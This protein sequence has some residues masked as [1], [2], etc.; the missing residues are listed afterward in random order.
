MRLLRDQRG[1]T[2]PELLVSSIAFIVVLSSILMITTVATHN[3]DRI[4][5]RVNANQRIRPVMTRVMDGLHSA[6]VT[7]G[8]VPIATSSAAGSTTSTS[9]NFISKS[10]SGVNLTPD[11]HNITLSGTTLTERVYTA[12]SGTA[13]GPWTFSS[14]A[15]STNIL[16]S[17]VSAPGNV[18]FRYYDFVNGALNPTPLPAAPLSAADAARVVN[19]SVTLTA[20]PT[21]GTSALDPNSPITISDSADL[22]L[23][24]ATTENTQPCS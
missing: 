24:S 11:L 23:E 20:A 4:A 1:F 19:V 21:P 5:K 6:C 22:R 18:V 17:N 10:G 9:I 12:L 16:L 2:L 13:P 7:R 3:Q 8:V 15:S 14:T